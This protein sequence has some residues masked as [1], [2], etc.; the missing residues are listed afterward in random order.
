M[1]FAKVLVQGI[2]ISVISVYVPHCNLD[3]SQKDDFYD[4]VRKHN[5]EV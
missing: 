2:A 1:S 5:Y 3:N 4:V